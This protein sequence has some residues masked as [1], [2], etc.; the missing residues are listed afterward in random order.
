MV[1]M[2]AIFLFGGLVGWLGKSPAAAA[3]GLATVAGSRCFGSFGLRSGRLAAFLRC[4]ICCG[5]SRA[6]KGLRLT[7]R[8]SRCGGWCSI[9]DASGPIWQTMSKICDPLPIRL[10]GGGGR[11]AGITGDGCLVRSPST[12]ARRRSAAAAAL[13]RQKPKQSS[14]QFRRDSRSIGRSSRQELDYSITTTTPTSAQLYNVSASEIPRMMQPNEA[15]RP[16]E[17]AHSRC[18]LARIGSSWKPF[19]TPPPAG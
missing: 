12:M 10:I 18:P 3:A 9:W 5:N 13:M 15:G 7:R 14:K 17:P 6:L 16:N 1:G 8:L 19:S 11:A 4:T 2:V